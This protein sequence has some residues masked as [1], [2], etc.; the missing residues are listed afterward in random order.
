MTIVGHRCDGGVDVVLAS[1]VV[2]VLKGGAGTGAWPGFFRVPVAALRKDL[3]VERPPR[4]YSAA[5][6][7]MAL[8]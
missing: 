4:T 1:T 5:P 3:V 7:Y 8:A 2:K 6:G